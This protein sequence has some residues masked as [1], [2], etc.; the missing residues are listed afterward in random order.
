MSI[1]WLAMYPYRVSKNRNI[2][3]FSLGC[4]TAEWF[5]H[6]MKTARTPFLVCRRGVRS[7]TWLLL[8]GCVVSLVECLLVIDFQGWSHTSSSAQIDFF[9]SMW[10]TVESKIVKG[11]YIVIVNA[12]KTAFKNFL[13]MRTRSAS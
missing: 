4:L 2:A 13:L 9:F 8:N 6:D 5:F 12:R 10:N 3:R 11:I 7:V 1:M